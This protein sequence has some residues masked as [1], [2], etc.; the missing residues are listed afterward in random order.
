MPIRNIAGIR[1]ALFNLIRTATEPEESRS[2]RASLFRR[3][4]RRLLLIA[5]G[6]G[7]GLVAT[8]VALRVTGTSF[9]VFD[10]YDSERGVC[11]KPGKEGWYR[12]E[13]EAYLRIN[14]LGYRDIEHTLEKPDGTFRIAFL[15]DSFTEAR[16][17]A[18]DD[19]YWK[20]LERTL[21][22]SREVEDPSIEVLSFGI[23][24]YG[25]A[26]EI[27]TFRKDA[28]RFSPDLVLL[29]F[30]S[31]ND[32]ANNSSAIQPWDNFRPFFELDDGELVLDTSFR[33]PSPRLLWR[34]FLL[35]SIHHSRTLELVN[36]G[37]RAWSVR[38]M[39]NQSPA[40]V[41]EIGLGPS[42]YREPDDGP[43]K[44]AWTLT[45]ALLSEL[46]REVDAIGAHFAV[47]TL[48]NP[49]QV[50]PDRAKRER[51][52]EALGVPHLFYPER[53]LAQ[54]GERSST[55]VFHVAPELQ[56]RADEEQVF[57]HGFLNTALGTGHWNERGHRAV[58]E[59]LFEKLRGTELLRPRR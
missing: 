18:I 43:L 47:V 37:R 28:R 14:S 29:A 15:G 5:F 8:E 59:I 39:Q 41:S 42:I 50:E 44:A 4:A 20:I 51:H 7:L 53:R 58:A 26:Q 49:A 2:Q 16:Q 48:S 46:A 24:G 30:M 34:R 45:E 23:G 17:V 55:R 9:P 57:F 13:G 31:G 56:R 33:D 6:L 12:K 27:L 25:T 21:N 38:Q 52:Q 11:L 36:Q 22:G 19:T 3:L 1:Q 35:T 32:L 54:W 40:P 10:T